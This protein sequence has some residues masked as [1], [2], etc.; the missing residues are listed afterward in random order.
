MRAKNLTSVCCRLWRI[1]QRDNINWNLENFLAF[2]CYTDAVD[3]NILATKMSIFNN[4]G[5]IEGS[6]MLW[7]E[8][9]V[10]WGTFSSMQ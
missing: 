5:V 2:P 6:D 9:K 4:M 3:G 10:N 8:S 1:Y 7:K